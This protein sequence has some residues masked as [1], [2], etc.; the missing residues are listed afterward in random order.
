MLACGHDAPRIGRLAFPGRT[1]IP[2]KCLISTMFLVRFP[3]GTLT[4]RSTVAGA[5]KDVQKVG[6]KGEQ[7]A[8]GRMDGHC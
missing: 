5:G 6:A 8:V 3:P 1:G 2:M 7:E 4:A